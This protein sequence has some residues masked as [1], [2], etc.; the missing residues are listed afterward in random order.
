MIKILNCAT[1]S[2]GFTRPFDKHNE[3]LFKTRYVF[4]ALRQRQNRMG[5]CYYGGICSLI[6]KIWRS[7]YNLIEVIRFELTR[8]Y[9]V[10]FCLDEVI[11]AY[12][13]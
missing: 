6:D 3:P 12:I 5:N 1:A 13:S 9:F 11:D 10:H 4:E 7:S 2:C 8:H